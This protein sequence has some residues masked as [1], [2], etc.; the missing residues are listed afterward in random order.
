MHLI[1]NDYIN[2]A[3]YHNVRISFLLNYLFFTIHF[4]CNLVKIILLRDRIYHFVYCLFLEYYL[5]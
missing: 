3:N 1:E 2:L 4:H 5:Y